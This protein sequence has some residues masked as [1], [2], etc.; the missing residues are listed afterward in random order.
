M[1]LDK[2]K[3]LAKLKMPSKRPELDLSDLGADHDQDQSDGDGSDGDDGDSD[4]A[5]S[6]EMEKK[7]EETGMD[8]DHDNEEGE[9]ADHADK[10]MGAAHEKL[11]MVSDDDLLAEIKKRGL[12]SKLDKDHETGDDQSMYS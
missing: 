10:V 6:P 8:L 9:P 11:A 3:K 4:G 5:E 7:E 2:S 12:M 1:K